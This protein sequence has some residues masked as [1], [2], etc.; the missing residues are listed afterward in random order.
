MKRSVLL[1]AAFVAASAC[2]A[3]EG[4]GFDYPQL[5]LE[6][7]GIEAPSCTDIPELVIGGGRECTQQE[8][9]EWLKEMRAWREQQLIRMGYDTNLYDLPA[10]KWAE[11]SFIQP[12]MMMEDRYFYDPVAHKYTVDRYLD[13]VTKRYGGIDSVLIWHTYTNIGI[14]NRNQYDLL[15]DM[16]GGLD[17]VRAMVRD[18]HRHGVRVFFPVMVWDQGTR[19]EGKPNLSL[20]HI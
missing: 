12:Q 17:A 9:D 3:A 19:D 18:F 20:I 16:P 8:M 6:A 11:S 14:D 15:R 13:D 1:L 2:I 5:K 7:E 4:Q 10:L